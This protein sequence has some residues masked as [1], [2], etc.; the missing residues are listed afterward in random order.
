[1]SSSLLTGSAR[2]EGGSNRRHVVGEGMC[3]QHAPAA[4][5]VA[6][7]APAAAA[8]AEEPPAAHDNTVRDNSRKLKLVTTNQV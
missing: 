1:M 8:A 4:T 6:V 3:T 2:Q 7:L 5:A